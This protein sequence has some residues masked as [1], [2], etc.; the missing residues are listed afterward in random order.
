MSQIGFRRCLWLVPIYLIWTN[1]HG[2]MLGGLGTMILALAGWTFFK[3]IGW[4]SPLVSYRQ[5]ISWSLL[6]LACGLT[7]LI[8]PYGL[9]LPQAWFEI[10]QADLPEIIVEHAPLSP[11][12]PEGVMVLLF[13]L[14]YLAILAGVSPG[15]PRVTWLIPLVWFYLACT[16]IRHSPLFAVTAGLALADMFPHTRWAR[17][18]AR[19]DSD[20]FIFPEARLA[21]T[22]RGALAFAPYFLP[23]AA[24]SIAF[25][26][27]IYRV[28]AMVIGLGP[29]E[30]ASPGHGCAKLDPDYWPVELLPEL[31][32]YQSKQSN[33]TPI[34][35]EYLFGGFLIYYTPGYRVFVDDRCELFGYQWLNEYVEVE[36]GK[37]DAK[38]QFKKWTK[39][40][41]TF[42]LALTR[43]GSTFDE[44][45][46][47]EKWA[48]IKESKAANFYQRE[49]P[50]PG[51]QGAGLGGFQ[52]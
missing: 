10:M 20:L 12:K 5:I 8:N 19:P 38:D 41:P 16:R 29:L 15:K 40:Y 3:L 48:V 14:I 50:K 22:R 30:L 17:W 51:S 31:E 7:I 46:R 9:A 24:V 11:A 23:A 34:F 13:G 28:P 33:G 18:L 49:E 1:V 45:F 35:N 26:L 21:A 43:P 32:R 27:L 52:P 4:E 37:R 2:G 42:D 25:S 47:Q 39:E 36:Q 6:I 44:Y